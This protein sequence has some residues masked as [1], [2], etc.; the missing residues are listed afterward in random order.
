MRADSDGLEEEVRLSV[1]LLGVGK[2]SCRRN[3]PTAKAPTAK[4][5]DNR[6]NSKLAEPRALFFEFRK[7][8]CHEFLSIRSPLL[9][10]LLC[11]PHLERPLLDSSDQ[12]CSS[13]EDQVLK[14]M[15]ADCGS[16]KRLRTGGGTGKHKHA[17]ADAGAGAG[18]GAEAETRTKEGRQLNRRVT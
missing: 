8:S 1:R 13:S 15:A 18:A 14:L 5:S 7:L 17:S 6:R 16:M 3:R 4:P 11:D 12:N 9:P 10:C 2:N